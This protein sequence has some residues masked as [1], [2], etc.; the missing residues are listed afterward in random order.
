MKSLVKPGEGLVTTK[1]GKIC[2]DCKNY[3]ADKAKPIEKLIADTRK[4]A[5]L[6]ECD[7]KDRESISRKPRR[8]VKPEEK[9]PPPPTDDC[10]S[11]NCVG[12]RV[13]NQPT[14]ASS[15]KQIPTA[16]P[17]FMDWSWYW[18]RQFPTAASR[19]AKR[20]IQ[21]KVDVKNAHLN[22]QPVTEF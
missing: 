19:V 2:N 10:C 8:H 17:R 3:E 18:P 15:K 6:C 20:I 5:K 22:P 9:L 4:N 12:K 7:A 21:A 1:Y 16:D 14:V 13:Y 11:E